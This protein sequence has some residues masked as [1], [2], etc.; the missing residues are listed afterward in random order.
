MRRFFNNIRPGF[1]AWLQGFL[2]VLMTTIPEARADILI[3]FVDIPYLIDKAPQA[4]EAS[5]RL[6]EEFSPR[7]EKIA[8][9][10]ARLDEIRKRIDIEGVELSLIER[11]E[12]EREAQ[13]H[14]RQ[15]KRDQVEFREQLNIRKNSEFKKIRLIVL[16]A[17]EIFGKQNQYDLIVSDG[18]LYVNDAV[19]VTERI[20]QQLQRLEKDA[21][22]KP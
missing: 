10:Q 8:S 20:L 11:K 14:E 21:A 4:L 3:G 22:D 5:Q 6:E 18:V 9:L 7:Q 2:L 17:I 13:K 1:P 12:L 16:N 19:D 15:I